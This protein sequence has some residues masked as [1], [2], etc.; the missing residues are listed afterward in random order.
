[1]ASS[2]KLVLLDTN[3]IL[4]CYTCKIHL[5]DID[6]I[7][8]EPHQ[9]VVPRNVLEELNLLHLKGKDREAQNTML[10]IVNQYSVLPLTGAVDASLL[11]Y[12]KENDCIICTNDRKLRKMLKKMGRKTI[13]VRAKSHLE[14]E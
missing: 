7:V 14:V 10:A 5:E 6:R 4:S 13:F 12:A 2:T 8:D 11:E 1:M 3:F 9:V